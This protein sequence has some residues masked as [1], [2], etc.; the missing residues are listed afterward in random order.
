MAHIDMRD[1]LRL[2]EEKLLPLHVQELKYILQDNFTGKFHGS[3]GLPISNYQNVE[4]YFMMEQFPGLH[5]K[6]YKR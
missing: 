2:L 1:F 5:L 4:S 6:I 3:V